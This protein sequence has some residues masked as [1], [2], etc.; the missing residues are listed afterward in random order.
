MC[1]FIDKLICLGAVFAVG[2]FWVV[3]VRQFVPA[4]VG[5]SVLGRRFRRLFHFVG[6]GLLRSF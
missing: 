3:G 4:G 5:H 1:L 6:L 2:I